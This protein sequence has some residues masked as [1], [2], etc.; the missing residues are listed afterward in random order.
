VYVYGYVVSVYVCEYV[1]VTALIVAAWNGHTETAWV[2]VS[3]CVCR[4]R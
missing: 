3:L 4:H 2:S 1:C